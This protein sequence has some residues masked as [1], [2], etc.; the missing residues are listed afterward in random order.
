MSSH[1]VTFLALIT[2]FIH[3]CQAISADEA[4]NQT[5]WPKYSL[6]QLFEDVSNDATLNRTDVETTRNSTRQ[7]LQTAKNSKVKNPNNA[8]EWL[9]H[10]HVPAPI[11]A[12]NNTKAS[13]FRVEELGWRILGADLQ[14]WWRYYTEDDWT[15]QNDTDSNYTTEDV[16]DYIAL[17]LNVYS[18][19]A[20][21]CNSTLSTTLKG[22]N[23]NLSLYGSEFIRDF[24][25][26]I[27]G[28]E[29]V[30]GNLTSDVKTQYLRDAL[31][32]A[33]REAN[34]T[35][36]AANWMV[37]A[38]YMGVGWDVKCWGNINA[39]LDL[40]TEW[41]KAASSAATTLMALIPVLLTFGNL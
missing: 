37:T 20:F 33:S 16:L 3:N 21:P 5:C 6:E 39:A 7:Q 40:A 34:S 8:T 19:I 41:D 38:S 31:E 10:M 15:L 22:E 14:W 28:I 11:F 4:V 35:A 1:T 25:E 29:L 17:D 2:L 36:D 26:K 18:E 24:R 30:Y 27:S 12:V 9:S 23:T 32:D 13:A